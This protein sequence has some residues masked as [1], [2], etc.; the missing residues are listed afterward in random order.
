MSELSLSEVFTNAGVQAFGQALRFALRQAEDYA[1][2]VE[3][4]YVERKEDF[5]D[6]LKKFLRRYET[7]ARGRERQDLPTFRPNVAHLQTLIDLVDRVGVRP[8]RAALIAHALVR[9]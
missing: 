3:L 9:G 2:L 7:Y 5:A 4:E 1:S 6:A 8:V